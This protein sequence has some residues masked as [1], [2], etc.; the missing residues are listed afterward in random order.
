MEISHLVHD[1]QVRRRRAV[2]ALLVVVSLI[3]LTAYFG[4]SADQPAAHRPAGDRR[5]PLA[6]PAGRQHGAR[7]RSGTSPAGS[8]TRST[9]S[10]RSTS[11]R[12]ENQTLTASS[13]RPRRASR[14]T[15][16]L[17]QRGQARPRRRIDAYHPVTANVIGRDPSALV[18]DD[19]GRQGLRRRRALN[20]PVIG[21]GALV[22]KVTHRRP[23]GLRS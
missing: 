12:S 1:K 8:R 23:D 22:G 11:C 4:E 5:G 13:L 2:L 3:L 10:R 15:A 7:R 16:Q 20:D 9:P 6:D 18:P 17:T 21:D 19:R 14:R